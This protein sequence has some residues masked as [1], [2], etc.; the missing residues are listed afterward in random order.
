[1][2]RRLA[3]KHN[4]MCT[5]RTYREVTELA[6]IRNFKMK[7]IGRHGG[8]KLDSKLD[9]GIRRMRE[10]F[11]E[12]QRFRPDVTVSSCSPDASRVSFGLGIPHMGFSNFPHHEAV[13]RLS[14]PLLSK[15]LIPSH[16][17]KR[18]FTKYGINNKNIIQY[19]AMD[20]VLIINNKK[21]PSKL[22][23]MKINKKKTIIFRTYEV[24]A[25]YVDK[26]TDV[27]RIIDAV[28]NSF[29][30]C[31]IIVIGRYTNEIKRLKG[32]Y[33]NQNIIILEEVVDSKAILSIADLFIG[34]GGT[35]TTE[36]VL[37]KTPSIS[38][39][40]VPNMDEKYL[41]K[42][43]LLVRAKTPKHIVRKT[44]HMLTCKDPR[45]ESNVSKFVSGMSDPFLSL[46]SAL[47]SIRH[48]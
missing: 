41:V 39:E 24:Q 37:R 13:M 31:N 47:E 5:S 8:D 27:Y 35:M 33:R 16:I 45:F 6:K 36:A 14:V 26:H 17:S 43:G 40:A 19:D 46:E 7:I 30:D 42:K 48:T 11:S 28:L 1:M 38:Y 3:R 9:A 25:S 2:C 21:M 15:L 34:S 18:Q 29:P 12:I 44:A 20:E 10:L 23:D 22:P 32:R 4:V